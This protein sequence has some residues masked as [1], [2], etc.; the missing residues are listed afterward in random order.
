MALCFSLS[1]TPNLFHYFSRRAIPRGNQFIPAGIGGFVDD[2]PP[3]IGVEPG[4]RSADAFG[5][6]HGS[7]ESGNEALD[8]AVVE[9]HAG[10][11]CRPSGC[12]A[13]PAWQAAMKSEAMCTSCGF[14]A[15]GLRR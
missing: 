9:D 6:R 2:L 4:Q 7:A 11:I 13:C 14:H 15:G 8:L 1:I 12:R 10:R 5:K 3:G